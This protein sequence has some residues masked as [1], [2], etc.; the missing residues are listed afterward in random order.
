MDKS[1]LCNAGCGILIKR[2]VRRSGPDSPNQERFQEG[3]GP[4]HYSTAA[5]EICQSGNGSCVTAANRFNIRLRTW[6]TPKVDLK[7]AVMVLECHE[8]VIRH[9]ESRVALHELCKRKNDVTYKPVVIPPV[10]TST[11]TSPGHAFGDIYEEKTSRDGQGR[12]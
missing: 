7:H 10:F 9:P 4:I 6:E 8:D 11:C 1:S 2:S 12:K 5:G 3:P